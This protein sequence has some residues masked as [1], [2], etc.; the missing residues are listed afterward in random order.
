MILWFLRFWS[1]S[2]V[3][4]AGVIVCLLVCLL[5]ALLWSISH[6]WSLFVLTVTLCPPPPPSYQTV[7]HRFI[8]RASCFLGLLRFKQILLLQTLKFFFAFWLLFG[9]WS[10]SKAFT[11]NVTRVVSES[12]LIGRPPPC[13]SCP[14]AMVTYF[15]KI[16]IF[17][18]NITD[19]IDIG[20]SVP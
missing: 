18:R 4:G 15:A 13:S 9:N 3:F 11:K 12:V 16:E 19:N 17:P 6:C 14:R 7:L 5:F 20:C 1:L 2:F 8:W 10:I